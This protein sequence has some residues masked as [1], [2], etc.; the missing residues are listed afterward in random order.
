M[1]K[2]EK[3]GITL[4]SLVITIIVLL[5]LAGVTISLTLGDNG[6]LK[7]AEKSAEEH[8]KSEYYEKIDLS[9]SKALANNEGT[10]TLD[11]LMNQIYKDNIVTEGSIEKINENKASLTTSE[12]YEFIITTNKTEYVGINEAPTVK[13]TRKIKETDGNYINIVVTIEDEENGIKEVI[14]PDGVVINNE[15]KTKIETN[16]KVEENKEYIFKIT[17]GKGKVRN[18]IIDV[19]LDRYRPQISIT[20]ITTT[21][22]T[23]KIENS[24]I[25]ATEYKYYVDGVLKSSGKQNK[26]FIVTNLS[27]DTE[28]KNIYVEAY[29]ETL[30]LT[31]EVKKV[32]TSEDKS[33]LY[34]YKKGNKYTDITGGYTFRTIQSTRVSKEDNNNYMYM[35]ALSQYGVRIW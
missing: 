12:G 28:Y 32:T 26:E 15:N 18:G 7:L 21:E 3:K 22:F 31:S 19:N 35:Y 20:N 1:K 9:K 16:Y 10:I 29:Y 25:E 4:I 14:K 6:I 11:D 30:K 8:K 17:N 23:I 33:K 2:E 5:I 34:L 13:I 27:D 24:D